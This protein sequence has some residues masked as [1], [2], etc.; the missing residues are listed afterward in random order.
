MAYIKGEDLNQVIIFPATI[1]EYILKKT[2]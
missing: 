1:D 2:Q